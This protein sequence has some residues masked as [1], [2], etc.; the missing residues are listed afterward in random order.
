MRLENFITGL[1]FDMN[2][3]KVATIDH[4]GVCSIFDMNTGQSNS[5]LNMEMSNEKGISILLLSYIT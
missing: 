3:E 4:Y 2:G 5:H 1:D